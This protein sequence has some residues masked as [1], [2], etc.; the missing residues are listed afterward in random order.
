MEKEE[1]NVQSRRFSCTC[2][3]Q[4]VVTWFEPYNPHIKKGPSLS[5]TC[6]ECGN[7]GLTP[8]RVEDGRATLET[9]LTGWAMP[10]PR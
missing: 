1:P 9:C 3:S 4:K 7:R 2:G 6:L 10:D 5:H 8:I